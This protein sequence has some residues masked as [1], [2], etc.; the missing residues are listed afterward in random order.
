[1]NLQ[2]FDREHSHYEGN[3]D[4]HRLHSTRYSNANG[5]ALAVVAS[6]K[7]YDG[8]LFDWS[9]YWGGTDLTRHEEDAV[10][11]VAKRGN[12]MSREDAQ[13]FFPHL[14]MSHYRS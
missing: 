4:G 3:Y 7:F 1:M 13:H 14:P 6:I 11:Y 10:R 8:E 2:K 12:K 9:A 5:F